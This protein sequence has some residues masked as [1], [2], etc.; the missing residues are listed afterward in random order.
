MTTFEYTALNRKGKKEQGLITAD[1]KTAA[2]SLLKKKAVYLVS[3][4]EINAE[5]THRGA[6]GK[7]SSTGTMIFSRISKGEISMMTRQLATLVSA[8]FNLVSALNTLVLQTPSKSLIKVI[9][10]MKN[11]IEEGSSFS[12]ALSLYPSIFT[13]IYINMVKA[14]ESSGT[15]DIVLERL[16]DLMEN[17]EETRSKIQASLAYPVLMA[18][19]GVLVLLFLLTYIV[20]GLVGIFSDMN[21]TLPGPTRFLITVSDFL[22]SFWWVLVLTV[23]MMAAGFYLLKRT[24]KGAFFIDKTIFMLPKIGSLLKKSAAARFSRILGSLL[25]HGV[26]VLTALDIAKS[27]IGNKVLSGIVTQAE[28]EVQQGGELGRALEQH[29]AFPPLAT[30]M[31]KVGEKSGTL[32]KM[33]E[34]TAAFYEKEV[35]TSLTAM[36]AMLEPVII[37]VMGVVVGFI[38]LSVCLPIFEMNQL[39]K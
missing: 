4:N 7:L 35:D 10:K 34:R 32:E 14:G 15:L 33:L 18:L 23:L 31:I 29:S 38:V 13:P 1:S 6:D 17:Q 30:Q 28:T 24:E 11:A 3:I 20:P 25:E 21:Q 12:Q 22:K 39:V 26:P 2:G 5:T 27:I 36:T 19:V 9:S 16:A 37:L 8:G